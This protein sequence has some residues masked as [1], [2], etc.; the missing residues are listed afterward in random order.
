MALLKVLDE[1]AASHNVPVAQVAVNW[2]TQQDHVTTALMGVRNP[3]EAS[4]NLSLIHI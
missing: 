3:H 2:S 4:E 1:V